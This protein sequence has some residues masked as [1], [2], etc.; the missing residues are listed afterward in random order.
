[1]GAG[2]QHNMKV[3]LKKY[4]KSMISSLTNKPIFFPLFLAQASL[5]SG[6]GTSPAAKTKNNFFGVLNGSRI[7]AFQSPAQSFDKQVEM[8]Q[9]P[10]LPYIKT[11]VLSAKTP[12]EQLRLIADSGYYSMNNDDT[13]PDNLLS[14]RGQFTQKQSADWYY[15]NLKPFIDD[16][17]IV[18]PTG[19][20]NTSN[21]PMVSTQIQD[22]TT[23][24]V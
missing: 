20:I 18:L 14:K 7:A 8:F 9:N 10:N 23:T 1:M 22:I 4:G 2:A 3:F 24:K 13:L 21:A 11:G 16:A 15:K 6:Y 12:Y 19:K 5:E 17:L